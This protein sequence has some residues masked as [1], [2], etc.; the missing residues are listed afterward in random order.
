MHSF[1]ATLEI[2]LVAA[3]K[4]YVKSNCVHGYLYGGLS[5]GMYISRPNN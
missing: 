5:V 4:S 3:T 2:Y 1:A